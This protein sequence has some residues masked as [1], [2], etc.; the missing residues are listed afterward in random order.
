MNELN[1][2]MILNAVENVSNRQIHALI[3][4]FGKAES[5]LH[6]KESDLRQANILSE[7]AVSN[8]LNFP[9]DK[10]L[11]TEYNLINN[12][13]KVIKYTDTQYPE[14]LREISDAPVILYVQGSGLNSQPSIAMVGSRKSSIYG[15][16]IAEK[17]ANR[18]AESGVCVVSGLARGIDTAVHNGCLKAGGATVAVLGNGLSNPY[19]K[20]NALLKEKIAEHGAVISEFPMQ[21]NPMPY[22]FPRRNRII[23]G[24]SLGVIVVE[25][26]EKSGA[27]ITAD[28]ALEQGRDVYAIPAMID[29]PNSLGTHQLIKQGA[30][31]M[32]SI[33]D[34]LEDLNMATVSVAAEKKEITQKAVNTDMLSE[35]EHSLYRYISDQ[36]IHIDELVS[37]SSMDIPTATTLLLSLEMKKLIKQLPGK[38]FKR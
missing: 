1:A 11:E 28:F 12:N 22:N 16:T 6:A 13:I 36:P 38:R 19:P 25:A 24:L 8:I 17:F 18:L 27:L 21:T 37:S 5:I 32:T 30:K 33:E 4:Y 31:L 35:R 7:T 29:H 9:K 26:A 2:L 23:S 3:Q 14:L 10:F 34:V 15:M 20:E